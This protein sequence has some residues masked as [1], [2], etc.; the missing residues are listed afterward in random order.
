MK[1]IVLHNVPDFSGEVMVSNVEDHGKAK[2]SL[3][4]KNTTSGERE[5]FHRKMIHDT[6]VNCERI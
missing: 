1:Y 3:W 2:L 6:E 5:E 4:L